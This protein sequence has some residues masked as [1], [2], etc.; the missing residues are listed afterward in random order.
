MVTWIS[1]YGRGNSK[2]NYRL[3]IKFKVSQPDLGSK[4]WDYILSNKA[5]VSG[6]VCKGW[7]GWCVVYMRQLLYMYMSISSV[8][9]FTFMLVFHDVIDS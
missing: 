7:K 1:R 5:I 6:D 8:Q 3:H 9:L 4:P 2:I